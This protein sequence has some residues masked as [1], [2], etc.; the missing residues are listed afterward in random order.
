MDKLK[1]I[2]KSSP[3]WYRAAY[4]VCLV[5]SVLLIGFGVILPPIGIIDNSILLA[6]GELF[7]FASLA[8]GVAALERGIDATVKHHDTEIQLNNPDKQNE[9]AGD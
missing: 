2:W 4:W 8:L 5:T 3:R 6:V 1:E 9:G 7:G